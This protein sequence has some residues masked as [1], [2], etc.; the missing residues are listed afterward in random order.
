MTELSWTGVTDERAA[1]L[2]D[3]ATLTPCGRELEHGDGARRAVAAA[4]LTAKYGGGKVMM[5]EGI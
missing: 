2:V 5:R 3:V 4:E 1:A